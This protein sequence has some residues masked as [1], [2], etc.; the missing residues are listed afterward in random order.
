M[1]LEMTL[2]ERPGFMHVLPL[3]DILA[4]LMVFLLLG[5]TFMVEEGVE[6]TLPSSQRQLSRY[7]D[8]IVITMS[9]GNDP[10]IF[11]AGERIQLSDL[12]QSLKE[13]I[14]SGRWQENSVVLLKADESLSVGLQ[15]QV[16]DLVKKANLRCALGMR[17]N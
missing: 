8:P 14:A 3:F 9:A 17:P 4:L 15:M 13:L 2:P 7:S 6:V 11:L 12:E 5:S 1:K 16:V 10:A